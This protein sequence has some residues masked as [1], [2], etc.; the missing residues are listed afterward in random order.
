MKM[1]MLLPIKVVDPLTSL[2]GLHN[3]RV[4]TVSYSALKMFTSAKCLAWKTVKATIP[5]L[6]SLS[7]GL[8]V[9]LDR[10][11]QKV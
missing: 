10:N 1:A 7:S 9:G 2:Y 6:P 11:N 8:R 3:M 5:D 4:H